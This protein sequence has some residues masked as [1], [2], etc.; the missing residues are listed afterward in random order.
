[1][2]GYRRDIRWGLFYGVGMAIVY[3]GIVLAIA[4]DSDVGSGEVG[5]IAASYFAAGIAS[6]LLLGLFRRHITSRARAM[7]LGVIIAFPGSLIISMASAP[8]ELTIWG[9]VWIKAAVLAVFF[10]S[11]VGWFFGPG[12]PGDF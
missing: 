11:L 12:G 1:M 6:G 5:I 9:Q 8:A 2:T 4:G 3:T 7:S 10:G